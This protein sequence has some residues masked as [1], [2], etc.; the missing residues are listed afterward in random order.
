MTRMSYELKK[1]AYEIQPKSYIWGYITGITVILLGVAPI[2]AS[3]F[4]LVDGG[5][6][7]SFIKS[8]VTSIQ[9]TEFVGHIYPRLSTEVP[10]WIVL[11]VI[12]LVGVLIVFKKSLGWYAHIYFLFFLGGLFLFLA[13]T[14]VDYQ[15]DNRV[16]F[17]TLFGTAT[18]FALSAFFL[19]LLWVQE[20]YWRN[21]KAIT[22][23]VGCWE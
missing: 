8:L 16:D 2:L 10:I 14:L 9:W 22:V 3:F 7:F 19:A 18:F 11:C 21:R 23:L 12:I 17:D 20:R 15:I 1:P 13:G 4:Y 5:W 6:S